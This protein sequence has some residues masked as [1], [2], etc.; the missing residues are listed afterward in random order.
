VNGSKGIHCMIAKT[1][2]HGWRQ[3]VPD[4]PSIS[5]SRGARHAGAASTIAILPAISMGRGRTM[6]SIWQR[7]WQPIW[8]LGI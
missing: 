5:A 4:P 2:V 3:G 7:I 1:V 6:T 8:L